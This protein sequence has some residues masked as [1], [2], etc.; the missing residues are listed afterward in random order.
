MC[1]HHAACCAQLAPSLERHRS[2]CV[3]LF[4]RRLTINSRVLH[5]H[6]SSLTAGKQ[7]IQILFPLKHNCFCGSR[8]FWDLLGEDALLRLIWLCQSAGSNGRQ[9]ACKRLRGSSSCQSK[10]T[11]SDACMGLHTMRVLELSKSHLRYAYFACRVVEGLRCHRADGPVRE[12][13]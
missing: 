11:C 7:S 2:S 4:V 6:P 12:R 8:T 1:E 5:V 13:V 10:S 3:S 9:L